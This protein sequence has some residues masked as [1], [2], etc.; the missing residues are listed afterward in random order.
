ME[1]RSIKLMALWNYINDAEVDICVI[2]K[3]N[4]NWK[5]APAHLYPTKQPHYWWENSQWSVTHNNHKTNEVV[6]KPGGTA[7]AIIN[8]LSHWAQ[9]PGNDKVGLGRW[10]WAQLHGKHNKILR[11]VSAYCQCKSNGI[12]TTYQQQVRFGAKQNNRTC[13]RTRFLQELSQDVISWTKE[14]EEVIVLANMNDDIWDK[15]I[16]QFCK[17]TS[18]VGS[19]LIHA[20]MNYSP[21][22]P[23]RK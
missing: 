15:D 11:I 6:Y 19:H 3:C 10:C 4:I 23:A 2:T 9:C 20:Q 13:P 21:H 7:L 16:I 1:T 18:L 17:D 5:Q 8:Q 14:G 12:L 22:A